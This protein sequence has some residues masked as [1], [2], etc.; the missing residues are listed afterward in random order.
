MIFFNI[1]DNKINHRPMISF[2]EQQIGLDI[3]VDKNTDT[4]TKSSMVAILY[5]STTRTAMH[6]IVGLCLS[7]FFLLCHYVSYAMAI[8]YW[9]ISKGGRN[10]Q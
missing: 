4:L 3:C 7:L 8:S 1:A 5:V 9:I 10:Y 6:K 2:T